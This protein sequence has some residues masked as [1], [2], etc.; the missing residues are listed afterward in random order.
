MLMTFAAGNAFQTIIYTDGGLSALDVAITDF[1]NPT[2]VFF[3]VALSAILGSRNWS[4]D[5]TLY[6]SLISVVLRIS[7]N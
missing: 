3:K 6:G 1:P 4:A 7:R 2:F 5:G